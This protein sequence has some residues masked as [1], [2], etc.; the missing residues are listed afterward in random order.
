MITDKINNSAKNIFFVSGS[1]EL[2]AKSYN[3]LDTVAQIM[4][5]YPSYRLEVNGY[6]DNIGSEESN[7]SL[8]ESRAEEVKKYLKSV[9]VSESRI[10]ASGYGEDLPIADNS[11]S[12]G[13][14]ENR[15]VEMHLVNY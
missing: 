12:E 5:S 8:S 11:S 6:T 2:L 15:R 3:S 1:A 13:R 4:K 9:G 10:I 7:K 14:A